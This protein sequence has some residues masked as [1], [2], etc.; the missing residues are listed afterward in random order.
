MKLSGSSQQVYTVCEI[1]VAIV[2]LTALWVSFRYQSFLLGVY[3]P[4][5]PVYFF[6]IELPVISAFRVLTALLAVVVV[7]LKQHISRLL[8]SYPLVCAILISVGSVGVILALLVQ[9]GI[10]DSGWLWLSFILLNIS[11]MVAHL[12]WALLLSQQF[13]GRAIILMGIAFLLSIPVPD[14]SLRGWDATIYCVAVP[15][16]LALQ[17]ALAARTPR[18]SETPSVTMQTLSNKSQTNCYPA[19]PLVWCLCIFLLVGSF[20]RGFVDLNGGIESSIG[21]WIAFSIAF[22]F[23]TACVV[24]GTR[25]LK[26]DLDDDTAEKYVNHFV[27]GCWA[28]LAVTLIIGILMFLAFEQYALGG[29]LVVTARSAL[30]VVLWITLCDYVHRYKVPAIPLFIVCV[31]LVEVASWLL[32]YLVV[33]LVFAVSA[34][35]DVYTFIVTSILLV[36]GFALV[37]FVTRDSLAASK[38]QSAVLEHTADK[39][40]QFS[41]SSDYAIQLILEDT[42]GL[43]SREAQLALEYANGYSLKKVA[44]HLGIKQSTAQGYIR[45]VYPKLGINS[46]D[47]LV[48]LIAALQQQPL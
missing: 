10:L 37:F 48:D 38:R 39:D 25:Y 46:K 9:Q 47:E 27:L 35:I 36:L 26:D 6:H 4:D 8:I 42:Y 5:L 3:P 14:M 45:K 23:A 11:L 1:I 13:G 2:G 24:F 32:S 17:I 41:V 12:S 19:N 30:E 43:T 34:P 40:S 7:V 15:L 44:E 20:V 28:A 33:P 22:L 18:S 16:A 21:I 29:D 31:V